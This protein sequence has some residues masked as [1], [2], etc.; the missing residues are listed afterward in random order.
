MTLLDAIKALHVQRGA[1]LSKLE[2]SLQIQALWPDAF[3]HG[4]CTSA[5]IGQP[6]GR[7]ISGMRYA[8]R[9]RITDG[10]GTVREFPQA[11]VPPSLWPTDKAGRLP[12]A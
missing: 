5:W 10:A 8:L 3:A 4:R 6:T 12:R 7:D 2:R 1:L 11:D 9:L